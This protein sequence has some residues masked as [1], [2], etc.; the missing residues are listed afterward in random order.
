MKWCARDRTKTKRQWRD[1][2]SYK[3]TNAIGIHFSAKVIWFR[4][5]AFFLCHRLMVKVSLIFAWKLDGNVGDLQ[6]YYG[7]SLKLTKNWVY[8]IRTA[9]FQMH[10]R[11]KCDNAHD[12]HL[13]RSV[14]SVN[15]NIIQ[16]AGWRLC[17]FVFVWWSIRNP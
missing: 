9:V 15:P 13:V 8:F 2:F 4:S 5:N 11:T 1:F 3:R 6:K 7:T 17:V 12:A 16:N 14:G 10:W